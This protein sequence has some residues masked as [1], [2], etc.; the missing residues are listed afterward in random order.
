MEIDDDMARKQYSGSLKKIVE[1][2]DF[3][4]SWKINSAAPRSEKNSFTPKIT[5][6]TLP[7][8]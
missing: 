3:A 6:H 8:S 7:L 5:I 1:K 4:I 2:I